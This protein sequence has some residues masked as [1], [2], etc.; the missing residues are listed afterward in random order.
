M[1]AKMRSMGI[2]LDP[3]EMDRM[4]ILMRVDRRSLSWLVRE[5]VQKYLKEREADI[6]RYSAQFAAQQPSQGVTAGDSTKK[7]FTGENK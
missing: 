6:Q 4:K 1:A 5:A 2:S 3:D 7:G